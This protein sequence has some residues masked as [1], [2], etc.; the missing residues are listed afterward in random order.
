[1]LFL[2]YPAPEEVLR[3]GPPRNVARVHQAQDREVPCS[4]A[5][6]ELLEK[7]VLAEVAR[8]ILSGR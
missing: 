5:Q 6:L 7:K 3:L 4:S 8:Q 1:M 2:D